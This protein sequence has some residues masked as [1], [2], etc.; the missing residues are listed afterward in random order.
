MI[1]IER[2]INMAMTEREMNICL[3][4]QLEMLERIE[5]AVETGDIEQIKKQVA[6]ERKWIERKLYQKSLLDEK[7]L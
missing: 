7:Y 3:F 6:L 2:Q 5:A 1:K 4:S